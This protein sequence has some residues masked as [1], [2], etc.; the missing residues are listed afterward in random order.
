[1]SLHAHNEHARTEYVVARLAAGQALALVSDAGTPG[2]SDPGAVLVAAVI[3]AGHTVTP[4]PGASA[5][6]TALVVSGLPTH[7]FTFI[8][9]LPAQP[10][11]RRK[12]L[13][14]LASQ[15]DATM[16]FYMPPHKASATLSDMAS[17]L[18]EHRR[19]CVARE[20]TKI[21]EE[22]WRG[23]LGDAAHEF[24]DSDRARG[25]FTLLIEGGPL[26][27]DDEQMDADGQDVSPGGMASEDARVEAQLRE[28][29]DAGIAPS[30]AAREVAEAL[31]VRRRD[32]YSRA[33]A[34]AD[35]TQQ[36]STE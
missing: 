36:T 24:S 15:S 25:E 16:A 34:M 21:Y 12:R 26:A 4:I 29:L 11:A 13:R 6:L 20:M 33:L 17:I 31:G 19:C 1:M 27:G 10:S 28:R 32:V 7:A 14:A 3:A 35:T 5:L 8:G 30:R 9:F 23:T 2:V 18:G 22:L